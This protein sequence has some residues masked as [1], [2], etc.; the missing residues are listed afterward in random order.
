M[1]KTLMSLLAAVTLIAGCT[2]AKTENGGNSQSK[3]DDGIYNV[4]IC[5]YTE[6]E[7]LDEATRGFKDALTEKL[8]DKVVFEEENAEGNSEK[9]KEIAEKFL[10]SDADLIMVNATPA[11]QQV[12]KSVKDIPIIATSVTDYAAA[13]DISEWSGATG[14]NVTGTSDLAPA[15]EQAK[16]FKELLPK[17]RT[18]GIL[19]CSNEI[20]SS[21]QIVDIQNELELLGY[22]CK[23]YTFE[24][25]ADV[26]KKTKEACADCDAVYIP[27]DN[28]A[29]QNAEVI[30]KAAGD[31][32]IITGEEGLCKGC[33]VAALSVDYYNLG[34]L[35]GQMAY[36]ILENKDNP[37]EMHIQYASSFA[38][39][40]V[41]ERAEKAGITV[42]DDYEEITE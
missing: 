1:K 42:P 3:T 14:T 9:C 20:N 5:R 2:T 31:V 34:T 12:S 23:K 41:P 13:L 22:E 37:A 18:I 40:Y 4:A 7:A 17:A 39:K 6:H 33:G 27:T 15:E 36:D 19:Y 10:A 21:Y 26:E 30:E 32:P 24:S 29:A 25:G 28:V 16:L 11:L 38:K 8:G 35:T